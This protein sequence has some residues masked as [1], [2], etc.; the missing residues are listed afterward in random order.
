VENTRVISM[1]TNAGIYEIRNTVNGHCYIGSSVSISSRLQHHTRNLERK[2]HTNPY[3]QSAC[4][5]Y[6]LAVFTFRPLIFC[7]RDMTLI[8]EQIFI[9]GLKPAY[10]IAKDALAPNKGWIFSD[11]VRAKVSQARIGRIHSEETRKRISDSNTGKKHSALHIKNHAEAVMGIHP[12]AEARKKMSEAH[13]GV[14]FSEEHKAKIGS[15]TKARWD[16][17]RQLNGRD[18]K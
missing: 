9:D 8:Y 10:N 4:N 12:S 7:D 18:P 6:G 3:L 14:N 16:L 15:K 17:W 11:E 2:L 5:K 13:S 1:R